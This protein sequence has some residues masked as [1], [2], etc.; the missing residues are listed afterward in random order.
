MKVGDLVRFRDI[1]STGSN[2]DE[3]MFP[4]MDGRVGLVLKVHTDRRSGSRMVFTDLERK[5]L[6]AISARGFNAMYFEVLNE[7]R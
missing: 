6:S 5:H 3:R 1:S 7:S 4:E 2:P